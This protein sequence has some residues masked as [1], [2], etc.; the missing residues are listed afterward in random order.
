MTYLLATV[1]VAVVALA[2]YS[3]GRIRDLQELEEAYLRGY[4]MG[5][6]APRS[7][8]DLPGLPPERRP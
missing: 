8:P 4:A 6:A 5:R 7:M 1:I 2:G 3:A